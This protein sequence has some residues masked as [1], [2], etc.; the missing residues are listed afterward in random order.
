MAKDTALT[1]SLYGKDVSASKALKNV[2]DEANKAHKHFSG[3][4]TTALGVFAGN[5][6]TSG[7]SALVGAIGSAVSAAADYQKL[8]FQ[9]AAV[10]KSTGNAANTSVQGIQDLAGELE[11]LSGVDE[12]L[13]INSENVLATFTKVSNGVGAGND[14][15]DQATKAALNMSSA[16]GTDLQGTTLQVGKALNDPVKGITA[17]SRAGVSFTE[18]QKSQI[19]AMVA[20]GDTMGAQ[21]L[22]L[23][24]LSTEFGGAAEAAGKGF[25]GSMARLKDTVSDA[26]RDLATKLLPTITDVADGLSLLL[27]GDFTGFKDKMQKLGEQAKDFAEQVVAKIKDSLPAIKEKLALWGNE[28][29]AWLPNAILKFLGQYAN[30]AG[31]VITKIVELLPV[32]TEKFKAFVGAASDWVADVLP[33]LTTKFYD[34]V[35]GLSDQITAA[36]PT[37][38]DKL[39]TWSKSFSDWIPGA[40][41]KMLESI[42]TLGSKLGDWI[43]EHGD[44]LVSNLVQWAIAFAGFV[45]KSIPGLLLNLGKLIVAIGKWIIMDGIPMMLKL[46]FNLG[47]AIVE[48]LWDGMVKSTKG[49]TDKIKNWIKENVIGGVKKLLGIASPSKVF[50]EMGRNTVD[51]FVNGIDTMK[52]KNIDANFKAMVETI[53]T[54][55]STALDGAKSKF[56]A[57]KQ[58]FADFASGVKTSITGGISFTDALSGSKENGKSFLA[59]LSAQATKA[60]AFAGKVSNLLTMGL[61]EAGIQ[62]V[63]SAGNDAGSA[64]A[65]ELIRGGVGAIQQANGFIS[66]T[67]KVAESLGTQGAKAFYQAGINQAKAQVQ[68]FQDAIAASKGVFASVGQMAIS[69]IINRAG[70]IK[71]LD[72]SEKDAIKAIS[73][74]SGASIPKL[75]SGGIV[76]Q[77]TIAMVGEAGPEAIIPLSK[78]NG[79]SG[80]L[81]V[82]INVSGSV[83]QERDLA[84]TVRDN[85]AQ[86]MRRR[87]LNPAILGV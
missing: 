68:G 14:I 43:S 28:F 24:E 84:V 1:Y 77:P 47:K 30:F 82:T 23:G 22:I 20:A 6:L 44:E 31:I 78:M 79:A 87:G 36:L 53:N 17:L 41:T 25:N 83:I 73:G 58:A 27:K 7:A 54:K 60:Q 42:S 50:E 21:K 85:I 5:L 45:L 13:I 63:L 74:A 33:V 64:I 15:F 9:T 37:I 71:K 70:G 35:L 46:V 16:L 29:V 80:G 48:G 3:L 4:K 49:F 8:G 66:A 40:V 26:T 86:L 51:G 69:E 11:S 56:E 75:A 67:D 18:Q 81:N 59:S 52:T 38:L 65:D 32:V 12:A 62:Q 72:K 39:G 55:L 10:L 2:G 76:S 57:A 34:L 61:S 19:K